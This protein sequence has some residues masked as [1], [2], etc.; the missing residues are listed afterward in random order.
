MF[1]VT[2]IKPR[3]VKNP[4]GMYRVVEEFVDD[5]GKKRHE[6]AYFSKRKNL[7]RI[8]DGRKFSCIDNVYKI[9]EK[10]ELQSGKCP[11]CKIDLVANECQKC[12]YMEQES[13]TWKI[14]K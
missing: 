1:I 5:K 2:T 4:Y 13:E 14:A 9:T 6:I 7:N 12:G 11:K 10:V 3:D 8:M